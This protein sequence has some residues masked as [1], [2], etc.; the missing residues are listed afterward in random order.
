[1]LAVP[2][3]PGSFPAAENSPEDD[4]VKNAGR[5]NSFAEFR[6]REAFRSLNK[7]Q[8][9]NFLLPLTQNCNSRSELGGYVKAVCGLRLFLD[10]VQTT[11][12]SL[13]MLKKRS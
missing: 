13:E 9:L 1:M 6:G 4:Q 2:S 8:L 3:L 10:S 5:G 11:K 12:H 7:S